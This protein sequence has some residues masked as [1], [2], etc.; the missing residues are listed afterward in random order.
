MGGVPQDTGRDNFPNPRDPDKRLKVGYVGGDFC[1]HPVGMFFTAFFRHHDKN[2]VETF[3]YMTGADTDHVTESLRGQADHWRDA[4]L[5]DDAAFAEAARADGID[6]LVDTAGHTAMNRLRA[7]A[8]RCAPVQATGFGVMGTTGLDGMDYFLADRFE[9]P[10]GHEKFYSESVVRLPGDNVCFAPPDYAPAVAPLPARERGFVAFGCFNAAGKISPEAIALWSRALVLAPGSR[11]LLKN[12]GLGVPECRERF[13]RLF[14]GHGI[15]ADRLILEGPA[16]HAELLAAYGRVD[17]ALDPIPY[18]GGLTT[19]ESLWMGV[20]VVTLPG[21]TFASRHSASH[22]ANAGYPELIA[23]DAGDYV[24]IALKLASDLDG[25]A[26]LRARLRPKM[27]ASPVCDGARYARGL[28]AAYRA[29]WR[30]WC[31][32]EKPAAL[33]VRPPGID[34]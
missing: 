3:V 34:T 22:L 2:A 21:E 28:E 26:N 27:A 13:I 33:D 6:I 10:P 1:A 24:A 11:M 12:F 9:I 14:S 29:M 17:I 7:F 19:L 30:R 18:S 16:T 4:A 31:Q 23:K 32:D 25:L 15:G 5:L 20:P 8:R